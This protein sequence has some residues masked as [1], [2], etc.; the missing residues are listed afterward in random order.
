MALLDLDHFKVFN[1]THGHPAG[2][3]LLRDV[4]QAWSSQLRVTDLLARYGGEEF[5]VVLPNCDVEAARHLLE[6]LLGSVPDGASA[7]A[8]VAA[9]DG[10]ESA[11]ALLARADVALYA[12]KEA[13][14]NRVTTA[15]Q[16]AEGC[17]APPT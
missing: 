17:P 9:W 5:A 4:A 10:Q 2:D 15:A 16:P 3:A 6:R 11:E 8:G 14:R 7:S 12:A 1:D 13:G